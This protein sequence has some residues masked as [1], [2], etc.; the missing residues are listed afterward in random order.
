MILFQLQIP[1]REPRR[2]PRQAG[3]QR[4]EGERGDFKKLDYLSF[5]GLPYSGDSKEFNESLFGTA[6]INILL[7]I[8][9]YF[10]VYMGFKVHILWF[11]K[12]FND[13]SS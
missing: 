5:K 9:G 2:V 11:L 7:W 8:E 12:E 6:R 13:F 4:R 1:I 10:W 3:N